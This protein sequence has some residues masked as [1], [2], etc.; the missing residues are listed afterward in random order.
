MPILTPE[1]KWWLD[2]ESALEGLGLAL[3]DAN[4]PLA[5]S[6]FDLAVEI[7]DRYGITSAE[8]KALIAEVLAEF[9][10]SL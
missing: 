10:L 1:R 7:D 5:R 3:L 8:N 2:V 6:C 9:G 4:I